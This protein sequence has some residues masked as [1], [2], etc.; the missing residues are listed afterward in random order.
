MRNFKFSPIF[1]AL[2]GAGAVA[3]LPPCAQAQTPPAQHGSSSKPKHVEKLTKIE[4]IA[5]ELTITRIPMRS[6][7]S[8][9]IIGPSAIRFAS[10]MLDVQNLLQ[11]TPS[12]NVRTP[13]PNGVRTNITFRSFNSGQF[14]ETF[15][16]VPINGVFNGG[17]TNAASDRNSIPLTLNNISSVN[18]YRGIN[19]PAVNAYNSLGGTIAFEPRQPGPKPDASVTMGGGSFS[20]WFYGI[21][22]NTGSIAGVR[23][24]ISINHNTS[25]GWQANSG[26]RN[27]NINYSGVLPYA[28][29]AGELYAY[30]I[31]NKNTGFTPHSIPVPL[32]QQF[33]YSYG[34]PLNYSNS[35]NRDHSGTYIIGDKM[36]V[37]KVFSFN[38]R[39]YA[40]DNVY[41]RV[42][43]AN[44]AFIQSATQPYFLPNTPNLP[45]FWIPNYFYPGYPGYPNGPTYNPVTLFG[46]PNALGG[47]PGMAYHTYMNSTQQTG[48]IPHFT[49]KLPHNLVQFGGAYSHT[50]L[51][52]AEF[53]YGANPM[54]LV[55]G[56]NDAWWENDWRTLG[57]AF[58]QDQISLFG[59]KVHVTPGLKYLYSRTYDED[60]IG[61]FYPITGAVSDSEHFVSPTLGINWRP[62]R[63]VSLYAAWGE[64]MKF[65][66][67]G[68]YYGNIGQT[69]ALG[70]YV[71][72]PLNVKPEYVR[73][74]EVGARYEAHGFQGSLN[75]YRENFTNTFISV[76]NPV[77]L[78]ST[79]TNGGR[80]TY[81]GL[82][83]DAQQTLHTTDYGDFSLFGNLSLNKAYFSSSF[84]Y[85]GTQVNPGMP[86]ANVP[87]HLANLGVGW[88]RGSWRANINLHY[89]SSQYLN[90]LTSGLASAVT[91]PGYAVTDLGIRDTLDL[92]MGMLKDV[93][94]AL[95]IDNVFNRHYDVTG[96]EY[97]TFTGM[98]YSS[99][100]MEEPRAYF[101]SATFDF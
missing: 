99:V 26:N 76:T 55:N 72:V 46:P 78:V 13:A 30:A 66:N 23:S 100:L 4:V 80:S 39:F 18:V 22:A 6:A 3:F 67:I 93:K 40:R 12:I 32:L 98:P 21:T 59:G 53:W 89:A 52:S 35:Y 45:P 62:I 56:Y 47:Y 42:S 68:A 83:L 27:L 10:P 34:W 7:Y 63:H 1:C 88:K 61:F 74:F 11:R 2:I 84:N 92:G 81:M 77:T 41:N 60:Q 14:S 29:D 54:P 96:F 48:F 37:N 31:Y 44:P 71:V 19:N 86:L 17:T 91:I 65:P 94:L 36:Q 95:H 87:R 25:A 79:T 15:A 101:A 70:Q 75:G 50:K 9:S 85:F 64:N 69:N 97:T 82:E 58:V 33:G 57:S 38:A 16:G 20:T 5:R 24:L 73:D 49:L 8:V 43:Y 28:D 90:Q 51:F